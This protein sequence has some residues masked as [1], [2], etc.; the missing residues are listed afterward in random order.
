MLFQKN[1][2]YIVKNDEVVL[3]MSLQEE[4]WREEGGLRAF[5]RQLRQKKM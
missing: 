4:Q 2:H 5:I 1:V 3:L